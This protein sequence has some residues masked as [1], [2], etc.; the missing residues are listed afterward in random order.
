MLKLCFLYHAVVKGLSSAIVNVAHLIP[1]AQMDKEDIQI[2]ENL[3]FNSSRTS[4]PLYAFIKHFEKKAGM[5]I[6]NSKEEENLSE[7]ERIAKYLINGDLNAMQELLPQVKERIA[8][9][10]I[11]NTILIDAMKIVG[12][13]FGK[14]E[15]Q[16]PFV[17]Q[18]AEVMKK[19]VDYLNAFLP[20]NKVPIKLRL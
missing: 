20:K 12:E 7:E 18:S 6:Q 13:K 9:E 8:P 15:M 19:S 10:K 17:L 3:I 14:G 4:E 1:Y 11:I 2:C 16:L 5:R